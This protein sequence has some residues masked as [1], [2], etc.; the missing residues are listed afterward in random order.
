MKT[1]DYYGGYGFAPAH[2]YLPEELKED[3]ESVGL[4]V[5]ELV[6]LEGLVTG[7]EKEVNKLA[8]KRPDIWDKWKKMHLSLCTHPTAVGLS[9]HMLIICKK[10]NQ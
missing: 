4:T 6:G 10:Q 1:G 9:E 2:F 8:K 5:L 3:C 7:H